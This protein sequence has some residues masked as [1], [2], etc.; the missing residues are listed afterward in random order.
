MAHSAV[1]FDWSHPSDLLLTAIL[2]ACTLAVPVP[3]ARRPRPVSAAWYALVLP[4]A[5]VCAVAV[6][7]WD[8]T[9]LDV[10]AVRGSPAQA[11]Q[12]LRA[13]GS[14]PF[15]DFRWGREVLRRSVAA[16]GPVDRH[17]VAVKDVQW[18]LAATQG[19][20]QVDAALQALRLR[21]MLAVGR[22]TDAVH[23]VQALRAQLG[24]AGFAGVADGLAWLLQSAGDHEGARRMVL[25]YLQPEDASDPHAGQHLE[26]L[27]K[28][29]GDHA[30]E[31]DRCAYAAVPSTVRLS[32]TSDPGAPADPAGCTRVLRGALE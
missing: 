17:G 29:N 13:E 26:I 19:M 5:A 11:A 18:A 28:L 24:A 20:A 3:R 30:D 16:V 22:P 15:R 2:L 31:V 4:L 1:D 6:V 7:R 12:V 32:S 14:Q 10:G 25:P 27:L 9:A 8:G 21:G 23:G